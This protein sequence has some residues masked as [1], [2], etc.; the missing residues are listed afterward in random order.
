MKALQFELVIE[1]VNFDEAQEAGEWLEERLEEL[2][3]AYPMNFHDFELSTDVQLV[4]YT[5]Q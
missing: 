5:P 1:L 4:T 2:C 3:A